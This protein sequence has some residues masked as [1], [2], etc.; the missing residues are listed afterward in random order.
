M[1]GKARRAPAAPPAVGKPRLE[2]LSDGLYAIALTLLVL[3]LKLPPL[4]AGASDAA[5]R[6]ALVALLPKGLVWMLSF[7]VIVVFWLA[8]QRLYR[9]LVALDATLVRIEL[10]GLAIVSLL[11]FSTALVGDWGDR[12]TPAAIYAGHLAALALVAWLRTTH[13]LRHPSLQVLEI[14]TGAIHAMRLRTRLFAACASAAFVLAFVVPGWNMLAM[15]PMVLAGRV[16][17]RLLRQQG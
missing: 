10:V 16:V 11:P 3:E 9:Y 14:S 13:F 4:P 8:Q 2:A 17:P 1:N 6:S 7:W 12:V 15:L 5:I